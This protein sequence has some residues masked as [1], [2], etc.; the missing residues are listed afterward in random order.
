MY[1]ILYDIIYSRSHLKWITYAAVSWIQHSWNYK[2][3]YFIVFKLLKR[4]CQEG[5]FYRTTYQLYIQDHR[6]VIKRFFLSQIFRESARRNHPLACECDILET[7]HMRLYLLQNTFGR[8]IE[9]KYCCF[10][11]GGVSISLFINLQLFEAVLIN[12]IDITRYLMKF[13][14]FWIILK[15][16]QNWEDHIRWLMNYLIYPQWL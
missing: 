10:F 14:P 4:K 9:K 16:I 1:K 8:H 5:T 12:I 6:K 3:I 15:Q 2:I 7:C 11:P 13:F